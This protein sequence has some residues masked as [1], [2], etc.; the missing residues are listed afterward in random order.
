MSI[1]AGFGAGFG[2]VRNRGRGRG[3]AQARVQG[4]TAGRG[5]R[6]RGRGRGRGERQA[7]K[8][9]LK[10]LW[11]KWKREQGPTP[12]VP[13]FTGLYVYLHTIALLNKSNTNSF[14]NCVEFS[15]RGHEMYCPDFLIITLGSD[16]FYVFKYSRHTR[17]PD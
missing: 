16:F 8:T 5:G 13:P 1:A 12:T 10:V 9:D 15:Y 6:G 17:N 14:S 2:P 4:Q 3:R 7:A 11:D